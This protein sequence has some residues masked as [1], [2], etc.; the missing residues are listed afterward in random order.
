MS[1]IN[2]KKKIYNLCII[3]ARKGSK[4]IKNKNIIKF[5]GKPLIQHTFDI[6]KKIIKEFDV[7]VSS[8]SKIIKNLAIKN[9]FIFL[10][11]RP[12]ILSNDKAK[13]KDVIR[14]ELK[15]IEKIN[16]KKYKNILLLQP[17]VPFRDHKKIL[18]SLKKIKNKKFDS[19]VSVSNVDAM[20]P[21]RMKKFKGPYL[22]N[23]IKQKNENMKPR[24][25]LP[26]V[27]IRSGA[28]YLFKRETLMKKNSLVGKKCFGIK[29]KGKETINIDTQEQLEF[30]KTKYR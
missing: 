2:S 24:Q 7:L 13:T 5:L 16:K 4:G 22:I 15:R 28:I 20:H 19:V 14:F 25:S 12:K 8:D 18:Y 27:F 30:L 9:N 10:G 1:K 11:L 3:P 26:E 23:Y 29:L 21:L 6:A 17:T